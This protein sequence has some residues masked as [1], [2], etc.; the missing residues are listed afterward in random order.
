MEGYVIMDTDAREPAAHIILKIQHHII[1]WNC[2][3]LNLQGKWKF[4]WSRWI[5]TLKGINL[6][7]KANQRKMSFCLVYQEHEKIERHSKK[8]LAQG[9]DEEA[10]RYGSLV[11]QAQ[12]KAQERVRCGVWLQP[13]VLART[14]RG[15]VS[16]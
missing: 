7:K 6:Q 16:R 3:F 13:Y 2:H 9:S 15:Y 8:H 14:F 5:G 11:G 12:A 10:G 1:Q 4:I